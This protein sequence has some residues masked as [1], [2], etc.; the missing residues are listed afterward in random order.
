MLL[1]AGPC[2][3]RIHN[4]ARDWRRWGNTPARRR[5][6]LANLVPDIPDPIGHNEAF[7]EMVGAQISDL[8]RPVLELCS[9]S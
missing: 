7:F 2:V 5:A 1:S 6:Q 3:S 9:R 4:A 8:L